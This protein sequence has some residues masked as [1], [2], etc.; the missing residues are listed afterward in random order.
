[1]YGDHIYYTSIL[2]QLQKVQEGYTGLLNLFLCEQ[3]FSKSMCYQWRSTL[4]ALVWLANKR[5][6]SRAISFKYKAFLENHCTIGIKI[7]FP[8]VT[9][10]KNNERKRFFVEWIAMYLGY[11]R[12][13]VSCVYHP[14][15]LCEQGPEAVETIVTK[16][17][18]SKWLQLSRSNP[19]FREDEA[20]T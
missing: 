8:K 17:H 5:C 20:R 7:R 18:N 9:W 19:P 11:S 15:V 13:I 1:M 4:T 3:R 10:W 6:L 2:K 16:L 14:K 12:F